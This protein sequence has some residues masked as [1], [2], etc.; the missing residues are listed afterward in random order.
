MKTILAGLLLLMATN[1][2]FSQETVAGNYT[3]KFLKAK[4]NKKLF[5]GTTRVYTIKVDRKRRQKNTSSF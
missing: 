3:F 2:S 4:K 5:E 1:L